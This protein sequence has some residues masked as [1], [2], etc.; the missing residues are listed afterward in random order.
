MHETLNSYMSV[1]L[2][3]VDIRAL[4]IPRNIPIVSLQR[5]SLGRS[6]ILLR[7]GRRPTHDQLINKTC[8]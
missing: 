4:T 1:C 3:M 8:P 5:S 6:E 7:L 2:V